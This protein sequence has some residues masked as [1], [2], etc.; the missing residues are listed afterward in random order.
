[1]TWMRY[2]R[3]ERALIDW[4]GEVCHATICTLM[5]SYHI[6]A[7]LPD[8]RCPFLPAP[9]LRLS[10]ARFRFHVQP[11]PLQSDD[12][13][14]N[15][16]FVC[17]HYLS[18]PPTSS[19]PFHLFIKHAT[20]TTANMPGEVI[21]RP[22]PRALPSHISDTVL[23]LA[24]RLEKLALSDADLKSLEL[25]RQASNYIAA[26]KCLLSFSPSLP[27]S[28]SIIRVRVRVLRLP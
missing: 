4:A 8:C 22:N 21:D 11:A 25:F 26:G 6:P 18:S 7:R 10:R 5:Q 20:N 19:P 24:V 13:V 15:G 17:L 2:H 16:L 27:H 14:P 12:V 3:R 28:S 23:D 1:M 9:R